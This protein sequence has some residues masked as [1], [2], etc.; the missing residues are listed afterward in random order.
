MPE[1]NPSGIIPCF[2]TE[3]RANTCHGVISAFPVRENTVYEAGEG[4]ILTRTGAHNSSSSQRVA[5]APVPE[6]PGLDCL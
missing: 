6:H 4:R 1:R 5:A 3:S 2:D